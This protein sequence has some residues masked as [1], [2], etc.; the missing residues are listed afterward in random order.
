MSI[1]D[2]GIGIAKEAHSDI[3]QAFSQADGTMTRSYGGTGLGLAI[4]KELVE[5]MGGRIR[6]ESEIGA[7]TE[8]F[9]T[10]PVE[11]AACPVD[12]SWVEP[13]LSGQNFLLVED[14]Q[15][16]S[17]VLEYYL[18]SWGA[19]IVRAQNQEE[20]QEKILSSIEDGVPIDVALVDGHLG[21]GEVAE[22]SRAIAVEG[23]CPRVVM[24]VNMAHRLKGTLPE[25]TDRLRK[26]ISR[27]A[28]AR[29]A[30]RLAG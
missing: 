11:P 26:P 4:S 28:L 19:S 10:L 17:D 20:A 3:F 8:F 15:S 14:N 7:G 22:I 18:A 1:R 23:F 6:L 27:S 2:T 16:T 29:L 13:N 9:I 24:L 5:L 21:G 30:C 25:S 12:R